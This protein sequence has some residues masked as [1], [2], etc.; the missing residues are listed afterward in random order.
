MR[1]VSSKR[2]WTEI[3]RLAGTRKPVPDEFVADEELPREAGRLVTP[4]TVRFD[5][6][7][8]FPGLGEASHFAHSPGLSITL[9]ANRWRLHLPDERLMA[10]E[11][12]DPADPFGPLRRVHALLAESTPSVASTANIASRPLPSGGL[13]GYMTYE[14]GE[15]LMGL[16]P[17]D[18]DQ[19]PLA[20]FFLHDRLATRHDRGW[21]IR[22]LG[23]RRHTP[24]GIDSW[25]QRL[26]A[27]RTHDPSG[28]RSGDVLST[29]HTDTTPAAEPSADAAVRLL[30]SSLDEEAYRDAVRAVKAYIAAGD[31]YQANLTR[32]LTLGVA[33]QPHAYY[34]ALR[35]SHAAPFASYL[36]EPSGAAVLGISPELFLEV[37]GSR[38][39]TQPIKGTR[40][41]GDTPEEDRSLR[42]E[43]WAS[44]KDAAELVMIVDLMRNDLGRVAEF[45]SVAVP[46]PKRLDEH[47]TLFHLSG[48]VEA[49]LRPGAT[50]WD[51]L[52]ACLPAGSITGAPKRRAMEI[53]RELEPHARG[54][55]TGAIGLVDF[56]GNA[57]FNVAIRTMRIVGDRGLLGVGG[58]IVA[59]SDA[60]AEFRETIT[61]ARAFFLPRLERTS[62]P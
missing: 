11:P 31:I 5:G 27:A 24:M 52:A 39:A 10:F 29:F 32:M 17:R 6:T 50:L 38:V 55:Y 13:L 30:G 40:P 46:S 57:T 47:P 28:P 12:Y 37:E 34:E 59:D 61:K 43:L 3:E 56:A 7:P 26:P 25:V 54:A 4:G 21:V 33:L 2:L 51:L 8:G 42:E 49:R 44:E 19:A 36:V 62:A 16:E 45:H 14:L 15:R 20:L 18:L 23:L 1:H 35:V 9:I 58:G 48:R 41:R 53:L 22:S 60:G